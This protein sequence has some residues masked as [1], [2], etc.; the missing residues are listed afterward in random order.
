MIR[1]RNRNSKSRKKVMMSQRGRRRQTLGRTMV[2]T[3]IVAFVGIGSYFLYAVKTYANK[4]AKTWSDT[5]AENSV[6]VNLPADDAPHQNFSEWWYYNGH[7][8]TKN[9]NRFA[10]HYVVFLIQ[11]VTSYTVTHASFI[12]EATGRHYTHQQRT[13]GNPSDGTVNK[14]HFL[15]GD[16]L[17]SG[18]D[19]VDKLTVS[20]P[21]FSFDLD[22]QSS[23]P[24]VFQGG[25]GLLDFKHAGES[26][27]YTRPRMNIMG[28]AG[29][30]GKEQPVSGIAWFDHQWGDFYTTDMRYNWFS[31]QL[32]DGADI[33]IFEIS[34]NG[35]PI[36]FGGTY[37]KAGKTSVF[38]RDQFNT[39]ATEQ[40][41]SKKSGVTYPMGWRVNLPGQNINL[42]L[43]PVIETSEFD[44]I[45]TIL[46]RYWE[47]PVNISGSQTGRGFVE[48]HGYDHD[49]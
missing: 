17:M 43:T 29:P 23:V 38:S 4:P 30:K 7:L 35:A 37:T 18:S 27:Y 12:D 47:G 22:L 20:T 44:G 39:Q 6:L 19:G 28:T 1:S 31:L 45:R 26:F 42:T 34:S 40:W 13:G 8:Q 11:N 41:T 5:T 14:F 2:I 48:M 10:F 9:K 32:D 25:T 49:S 3:L 46:S 16:S 21:D 15:I 33:M 24:T 36:L